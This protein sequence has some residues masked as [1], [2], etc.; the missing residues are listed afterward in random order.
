MVLSLDNP[1]TQIFDELVLEK[2]PFFDTPGDL[3]A[4]A[5]LLAGASHSSLLLVRVGGVLTWGT[6]S[7]IGE[8]NA[9]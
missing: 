6:H 1:A 3:L 8:A 5:R 4:V 2:S 7:T 9:G